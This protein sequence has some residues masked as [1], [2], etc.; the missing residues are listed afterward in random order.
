MSEI[1][2]KKRM[3]KKSQFYILTVIILSVIVFLISEVPARTEKTSTDHH[4]LYENFV[5][6]A[7]KV[8][9]N[10]VY[11]DRNVSDDIDKFSDDFIYYA[12]TKNINLSLFYILVYNEDIIISNRLGREANITAEG[13]ETV[14]QSSRKVFMND[15]DRINVEIGSSSYP[16]SIDAGE[17]QFKLIFMAND[18]KNDTEVYVY[19]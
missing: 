15:K 8:I 9:N 11:E 4:S 2:A 13:G 19:G 12:G 3:N 17:T 7:P 16:F 1:M 18:N 6:E 5:S 14:I 10:A